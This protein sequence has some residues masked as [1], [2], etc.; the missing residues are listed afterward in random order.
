MAQAGLCLPLR[1][2]REVVG[3]VRHQPS[4]LGNPLVG[5]EGGPS[6]STLPLVWYVAAGYLLPA[7]IEAHVLHY[8]T[9]L[10]EHGFRT[11]VV[12]FRP[13]PCVP[14]RFLRALRAHKIAITSLESCAEMRAVALST[15]LLVPW[16]VYLAFVRRR[17]PVPS[18]FMRWLL[19]RCA[20]R[21][22]VDLLRRERPDVV[23]VFGRLQDDAWN[24][25]PSERTIFHEMMTGE[26][27]DSWTENEVFAFRRF[28]ERTALVFAPGAGIAANLR[29]DFG[30][31][32]PI[33]VVC[34]MAPDE[35][36]ANELTESQCF[37][38]EG[39]P[40]RR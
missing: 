35:R 6:D 9:E 27:D 10:R 25:L 17:V 22:L 15:L 29:H 14:H 2:L 1:C 21:T 3:N 7:G 16:L 32:R 8:A 37:Q 19:C 26:M 33:Q 5:V 36:P 38:E 20:V 39:A 12:V 34:T 40:V 18:V 31:K 24:C 13:L 28:A 23:H 11:R 30:M 4:H